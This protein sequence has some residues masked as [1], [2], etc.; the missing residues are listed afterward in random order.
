[1]RVWQVVSF[2]RSASVKNLHHVA[3]SK[4]LLVLLQEPADVSQTKIEDETARILAG[5]PD[6]MAS[7]PVFY[8]LS[9]RKGLHHLLLDSGITRAALSGTSLPDASWYLVE[10]SASYGAG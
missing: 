1:V 6:R 3:M 2:L 4:A 10:A 8:V 7:V 5:Q 9:N